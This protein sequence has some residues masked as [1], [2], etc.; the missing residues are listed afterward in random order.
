MVENDVPWKGLNHDQL[1]VRWPLGA[2]PTATRTRATTANTTSM[3]TSTDSRTRCT[4]AD[5]SMPR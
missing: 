4:M 5:T 2:L 3:M 1:G